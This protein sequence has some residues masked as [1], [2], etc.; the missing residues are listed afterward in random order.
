[1]DAGSGGVYGAGVELVRKVDKRTISCPVDMH[2][3]WSKMANTLENVPRCS[4]DLTVEGQAWYF[5]PP[6]GYESGAL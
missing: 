3:T 4:S 5:L 2:C 1:M 6:Q